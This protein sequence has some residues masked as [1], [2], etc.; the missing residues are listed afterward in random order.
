[1]GAG[2]AIGQVDF[3]NYRAAMATGSMMDLDVHI[4]DL[5]E[6]RYRLSRSL[7]LIPHYTY[8]PVGIYRSWRYLRPFQRGG[9]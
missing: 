7:N 5:F 6:H 4:P 3:Q 8:N 1:M 2:Y 9:L